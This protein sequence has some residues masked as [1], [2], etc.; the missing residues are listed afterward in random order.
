[1]KRR[2]FCAICLDG[3]P[4]NVLVPLGASFATGAPTAP[5]P[6]Y[7]CVVARR[8]VVEPFDLPS[9]ELQ[10]F[11]QDAMI[12]GRA[13]SRLLRPAKINYEIHGNSMPHLH[14]HI[15]PRSADD[16]YV[17][18]SIAW[19]VMFDRSAAEL[20]GIRD[21]IEQE[22]LWEGSSRRHP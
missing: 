9:S 22:C 15:Y 14:M 21:A 6:G 19:D 4:S 2:E 12:V 11:W 16:P 18:R 10:Q 20:R 8:H 7:V 5:L 3:G 17:G 1:M 13:L